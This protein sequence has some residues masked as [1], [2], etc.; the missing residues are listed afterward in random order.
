MRPV[1]GAARVTTRCGLECGR[2]GLPLVLLAGVFGCAGHG[3]VEV[4]SLNFAAIDPPAPPPRSTCLALDR[5]YWW[6]EEDGTVCVAMQRDIAFAFVPD[7][8]RFRLS[9]R[10]ER[11]PAGKARQYRVGRKELRAVARFGISE[12]RFTS[13]A[14]IVALYREPHDRLR[15]SFRLL[16]ERRVAGLLGGFGAPQRY[17]FQGTFVAVRDRQR[18]QPIL[19]ATESG[20]FERGRG[21]PSAESPPST[22]PARRHEGQSRPRW[23]SRA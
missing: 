1:S 11:L 23:Q 12:S 3:T 4:A 9:L 19:E 2:F 15:G 7:R 10:L 17:L 14:G 8:F 21:R 5:C 20:G 22:R 16:V 13:V 6:L 18:G